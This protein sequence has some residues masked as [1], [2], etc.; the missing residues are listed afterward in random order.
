M[1]KGTLN[2][3]FGKKNVNNNSL[4]ADTPP[5]ILPQGTKKAPA[6][7]HDVHNSFAFLDDS[8]TATLKSR[9]GPRVRPTLNFSTSNAES[10]VLAVPTPSVPKGFID[11]ASIGNGSKLNGNYRMYSSV[12]DLRLTNY[13]GDYHEEI[14]APPNMP[15]P[16]PPT[17][18]PPPPPQ[19]PPSS[20]IS[21]PSSPS[22]PDFIP[23][24]PN[25]S[26]F[27]PPI[28]LPTD[29]S[30]IST[31]E[32]HST[33]NVAKWK[34]E[35]GLNAVS[36]DLPMT[37]P[38]RFTLNPAA[39]QY[40]QGQINIDGDPRSTLPKSFKIPPPAP[41]R[42]SSIQLQEPQNHSYTKDAPPSPLA[43]T[44]NPSFQARLFI[45]NQGQQSLS[46]TLNKRK[47]MLIMEDLPDVLENSDHRIEKSTNMMDTVGSRADDPNILH[48]PHVKLNK[49]IKNDNAIN[50]KKAESASI[51]KENQPKQPYKLNN[52]ISELTYV[53][54]K[55]EEGQKYSQYGTERNT[56]TFTKHGYTQEI[57]KTSKPTV[58]IISLK[59]VSDLL[60]SHSNGSQHNSL[61]R[62]EMDIFPQAL[63]RIDNEVK[64]QPAGS[65]ENAVEQ[66]PI[67]PSMAPPPPP[68]APPP[69]PP[70]PMTIP[71]NQKLI[72]PLPL[73]VKNST[74]PK[75]S[76]ILNS[77][78]PP[79]APPLD[80]SP[81]VRMPSPL[82]SPKP[83][84]I[85]VTPKPPSLVP[86]PPPPKAPPA[87]PPLPSSLGLFGSVPLQEALQ[88]KQ[89]TLKNIPKTIEIRSAQT[90][91]SPS[92]DD[93]QKIRVG[94]I[95]GELEALFSPK[96]DEKGQPPKNSRLGLEPN[97][98]SS[99]NY[100]QS[101]GGENNLVN[102]LMLKV[103]LLPA[104]FERDEGDADNSEWLPKSNK[105]DIH[106]PEPDYLPA[107]PSRK[108]EKPAYS[109][110]QSK[111]LKATER[112]VPSPP[113]ASTQK[114]TRIDVL[115]SSVPTYKPHRGIKLSTE[116]GTLNELPVV[117]AKP[118]TDISLNL[119]SVYPSTEMANSGPPVKQ[120]PPMSTAESSN[121]QPVN[122]GQVEGGSP[123]ALLMAAQKRAQKVNSVEKRNLPKISVTN[124]LITSSSPSP[125]SERKA[126]TFLVVPNKENVG[127]LAEE[128]VTS[129]TFNSVHK[130]GSSIPSVWRAEKLQSSDI[131][132]SEN[133]SDNSSVPYVHKSSDL[134]LST[135]DRQEEYLKPKS[136]FDNYASY[137]VPT[138]TESP[139]FNIS[140]FP[141][142]IPFQ[143][144]NN[145]I[146]YGIIPPPAEFMNSPAES[147]SNLLSMEQKD[148]SYHSD[149]RTSLQSDLL[150]NN[151]R[152]NSVIQ[153][154][155][156]LSTTSSSGFNSYS[157]DHYSSGPNREPQRSSLIKKRL[158]MPEPESLRNYGLNTSS[159]RSSAM[160]M[161]YMHSQFS[162]SMVPDPRRYNTTSRYLPQ[163]RRLSTEN[164]SR[165][166]PSMTD[167]KYRSPNSDNLMGKSSTRSQDK[168]QQGLTFTVRPGTRQPISQMYQGGY[169]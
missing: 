51:F 28:F 32:P 18:A 169:L 41:T 58:K 48:N 92:V 135:T 165:M 44:F 5:W 93:E 27:V 154:F 102:S 148:R 39:L 1:K 98:N 137:T 40:N 46:D 89:Q 164:I 147:R 159:I 106:I 161:S 132:H 47:S 95:K 84:N 16:P 87:P 115:N 2:K 119:E 136:T 128:E 77:T 107:S 79:P 81:V 125:A 36:K 155:A 59:P 151:D 113:V 94:K 96:K 97:K 103:P 37:L 168:N 108:T 162:S 42:I 157:S 80:S 63:A 33:N 156:S 15:P 52:R 29:Q 99:G 101:K 160:P 11:N 25:S 124:G 24:T 105:M 109:D 65:L 144:M 130:L 91:S 22:P 54:A 62:K 60:L 68:M 139:S 57:Q 12:G 43:S 30:A 34:S 129:F 7:Y 55:G 31:T 10:Q 153:P 118:D 83:K 26:A 152:N 14:P 38:N 166:G 90:N 146:K 21:S 85:S 131:R 73:P 56:L 49:E 35:T 134:L 163:G 116:N 88:A 50:D 66:P 149:H 45:S 64:T 75:S 158:Y 69:P 127:P 120:E 114:D 67:P 86:P 20:A 126:S 70:L 19:S 123:M 72:T 9:P 78:A 122:G 100:S 138:S 145:E 142:P 117:I 61:T 71:P 143:K 121:K 74:P 133:S 8:G 6:D 112:S 23:P 111:I 53:P 167:M 141:S 76:P 4:Y 104:K 82:L 150:P 110:V 17:M 3:L 13:Y 140:S